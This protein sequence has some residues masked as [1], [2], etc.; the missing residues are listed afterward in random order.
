MSRPAATLVSVTEPAA[1]TA[2]RQQRR[3]RVRGRVAGNPRSRSTTL[4]RARVRAEPSRSPWSR[5]GSGPIYDGPASDP[6]HPVEGGLDTND[7]AY[8][9]DPVNEFDLD[10]N[11]FCA[12][13][14]NPKKKGEKHGGCRGGGAARAVGGAGQATG[15]AVARTATSPRFIAQVAAAALA[16]PV[17]AGVCVYTAGVGCAAA[18]VVAHGATSAVGYAVSTPEKNRS[19]GGYSRYTLNPVNRYRW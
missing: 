13:G 10:G 9:K 17:V 14:H 11:G 2:S 16:A 1:L 4:C 19:W 3:C 7:Y 12:A 6:S 18:V 8:V 5:P 15:R